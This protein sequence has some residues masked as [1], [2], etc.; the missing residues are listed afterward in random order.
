MFIYASCIE[1]CKSVANLAPE[2]RYSLYPI[3]SIPYLSKPFLRKLSKYAPFIFLKL[4]TS[5]CQKKAA[6]PTSP[7]ALAGS[8]L[9]GSATLYTLYPASLVSM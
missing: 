5:A 6:Y 8:L 2:G 9:Y 3:S 4:L 1:L 7:V